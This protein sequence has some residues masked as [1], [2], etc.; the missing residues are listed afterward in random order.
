MVF[1][2]EQLKQK[3]NHEVEVREIAESEVDVGNRIMLEVFEFPTELGKEFRKLVVNWMQKGGRYFVGYVDGKP[4]GTSFLLSLLKT[5]GIF[6][7][8]T[9]MKYR[10]MGIGTT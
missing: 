4:V 2:G 1:K 6:S 9:L 10:R 3:L 7:V 5:G 8:G